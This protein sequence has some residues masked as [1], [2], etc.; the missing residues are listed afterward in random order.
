MKLEGTF[1]NTTHHDVVH[2]IGENE[3]CILF[4]Y[5]HPVKTQLVGFAPYQGDPCQSTQ[6]GLFR[7]GRR[8]EA[9]SGYPCFAP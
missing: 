5:I 4:G 8:P 9:V 6:I 2:G 3:M 1:K 7:G